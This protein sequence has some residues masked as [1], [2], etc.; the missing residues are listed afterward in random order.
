MTRQLLGCRRR[1]CAF[2]QMRDDAIDGTLVGRARTD[3]RGQ[4]FLIDLRRD[5]ATIKR[6]RLVDENV[7]VLRY[8]PETVERDR[9][10]HVV[11]ADDK[12][13]ALRRDCLQEWV[14]SIALIRVRTTRHHSERQQRDRGRLSRSRAFRRGHELSLSWAASIRFADLPGKISPF[15][16]HTRDSMT[17]AVSVAMAARVCKSV[18]KPKGARQSRFDGTKSSSTSLHCRR[19]PAALLR[20]C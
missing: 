16:N 4:G 8:C 7:V 11:A 9:L 15:A 12:R 10:T 13:A 6:F 18:R 3:K 5:P 20:I 2:G 14:E 17:F 19:E 1:R